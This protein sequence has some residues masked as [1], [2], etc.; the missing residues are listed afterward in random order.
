MAEAN[1]DDVEREPWFKYG[2]AVLYIEMIIAIMVTVFSLYLAF[3]GQAG[4][5]A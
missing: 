3:Q 1:A 2:K 5:I 4:A